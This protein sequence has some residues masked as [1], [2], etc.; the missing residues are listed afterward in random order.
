MQAASTEP[1]TEALVRSVVS[2]ADALDLVCVAEGIETLEQLA[3]VRGHGCRLG[4]G[5]L[6]ARPMPTETLGQLV[7]AGHVYPVDV[8]PPARPTATRSASVVPLSRAT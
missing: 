8:S 4:Q 2:M 5:Y 6:L 7:A 1:R 3:L